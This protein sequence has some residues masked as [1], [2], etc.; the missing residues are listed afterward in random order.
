MRT[1]SLIV[2]LVCIAAATMI[3]RASQPEPQ[4]LRSPFSAFP[5]TIGD[6]VGYQQPAFDDETL[7]L[8]GLDDYVTRVYVSG[9]AGVG[10]YVG[11]WASQR[12]GDT[13]H[14]PL[15]C[16]P[17]SGWDPVSKTTLAIDTGSA[18]PGGPRRMSVNRYVVEKGLERQLVLYW[19][20]SHGRVV[21]SEYASKAFLVADA[22]RLHRTDAALVRIVAPVRGDGGEAAA[23]GEAVRFVRALVP[24]LGGYLPS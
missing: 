22:I 24:A 6:W 13:I 1:R 19:Y 4:A 7:K 8:L 17:G 11:Y 10:L 3:A 18:A 15:N 21:A 2:L 20:Q 12:E 23:E 14:S 9:G 5:M 16:L